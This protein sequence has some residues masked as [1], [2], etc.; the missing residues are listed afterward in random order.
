[1]LYLYSIVNNNIQKLL[2]H[3]KLIRF[4]LDHPH[5]SFTPFE[6]SKLTHISYPTVWRYVHH[7]RD[8]NVIIVERIGRY[9]ICSLNR[10]SPIAAKLGSILELEAALA[11]AKKDR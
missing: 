9:N 8:F 5:R 2:K 1:M 10:S 7:L 3:P 11:E 6:L 4:L